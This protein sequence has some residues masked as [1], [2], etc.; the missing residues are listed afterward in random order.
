MKI[1]ESIQTEKNPCATIFHTMEL[2]VLISYVQYQA[3]SEFQQ[4]IERKNIK[5]GA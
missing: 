4:L 5:K 1:E 3:S 2:I